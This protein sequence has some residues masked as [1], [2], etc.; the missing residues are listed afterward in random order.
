MVI[1]DWK[2]DILTIPNLLSLFRLVL[3]PVYIV[4]Y[5]NAKNAADYYIAGGILAVSCLTDAIDGKIADGEYAFSVSGMNNSMNAPI[6]YSQNQA[7]CMTSWDAENLYIAMRSPAGNAKVTH[8]SPDAAI[9]ED[10]AVE[11]FI[12]GLDGKQDQYQFIFNGGTGAYHG[13]N[14]SD[15]W[16]PE[17]LNFKSTMANGIWEFECAIPWKTFDFTPADGKSFRV[18]FARDYAGTGVWTCLAPGDYFAVPSYAKVIL[19]SKAPKFQLGKLG[20]LYDG[21]L[22]SSMVLRGTSA[23]QITISMAA[24][25]AIFPFSHNAGMKIAKGQKLTM[26]LEGKLPPNG[27]LEIN[28]SSEKC[29]TIY[30]NIHTYKTLLPSRLACIYT[31]IPAQ[32]LMMEVENTRLRA[33]KISLEVTLT[34]KKSGKVALKESKLI[35]DDTFRNHL[36]YSIAGIADGNYTLAYR[37]LDANGKVLHQDTEEYAKY[38]APGPALNTAMWTWF[39]RHGPP[40][41]P[42]KTPSNAGDAPSDSA[43]A[44][45]SAPL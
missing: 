31:D 27:N 38:P 24:K 1:K 41:W 36:A 11:F 10:D 23:D 12:S 30:K 42:P 25:A 39:P 35:P 26:P 37:F 44:P 7:E 34:E 17:G 43:A 4:I 18:N 28:I 9:W 29:G 2:K 16:N 3:I 5:L 40:R 14:R 22:K 8:T 32:N 20:E 33:G 19:N 6:Q 15:K 21:V 13:K 45:S